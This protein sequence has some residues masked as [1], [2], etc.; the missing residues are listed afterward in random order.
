ILLTGDTAGGVWTF[1]LDLAEGL[2]ERG[3]EICLATFGPKLT[4][5]QRRSAGRIN[6]MQWLHHTSKLEWMEEPWLDLKVAGRWLRE[7][8]RAYRPE[9][10]HLNTLYHANRNWNLPVVTTVHSCVASWWAAVRKS[11]LPPEWNRYRFEVESSLRSSTLL[12]A[13]SRALLTA[14]DRH[15]NIDA[16]GSLVIHNGRNFTAFHTR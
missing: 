10:I 4:D 14:V 6:G 5:E 15:Y 7:V 2:I 11:P 1:A 8:A 13:P 16:T 12:I 9:L 3:L